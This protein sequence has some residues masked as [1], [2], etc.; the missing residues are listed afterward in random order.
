ML[1]P[2]SLGFKQGRTYFPHGGDR[3]VETIGEWLAGEFIEQRLRVK[4]IEM[5]GATFHEKKDYVLRFS[6]VVG[7]LGERR[8]RGSLGKQRF[9]GKCGEC[10]SSKAGPGGIKK[11]TAVE[12]LVDSVA[13]HD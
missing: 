2:S 7:N 6:P 9:V 4:K 11:M 3:A 1:F 13:G 8:V 5:A 12:W 10:N